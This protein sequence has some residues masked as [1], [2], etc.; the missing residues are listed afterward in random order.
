LAWGPRGLNPALHRKLQQNKYTAT[1]ASAARRQIIVGCGAPINK[2]RRRRPQ[3][4]G[5][6]G[7]AGARLYMEPVKSQIR[8]QSNSME[9]VLTE[10]K[11]DKLKVD[12]KKMTSRGNNRGV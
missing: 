3:I 5:G 11:V 8:V 4:V 2:S 12:W 9:M 7:A 6:G 1:T 10:E